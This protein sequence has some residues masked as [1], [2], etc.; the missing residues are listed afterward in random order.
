MRLRDLA[1]LWPERAW[2]EG[3]DAI[4]CL[5]L[6]RRHINT[7]VPL[8]HRVVSHQVTNGMHL[9]DRRQ[10]MHLCVLMRILRVQGVL[11]GRCEG[12]PAGAGA[13]AQGGSVGILLSA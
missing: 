3:C 11:A 8:T 10:S 7:H 9:L 2:K 6:T 5:D 13:E 12:A 4:P 1:L